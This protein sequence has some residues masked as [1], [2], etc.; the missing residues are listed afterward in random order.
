MLARAHGILQSRQS[1]RRN[2]A[3]KCRF[4]L[5][6]FKRASQKKKSASVLPLP[7][8]YARTQAECVHDRSYKTGGT[9]GQCAK[10]AAITIAVNISCVVL[11]SK[12]GGDALTLHPV[13]LVGNTLIR[14]YA[15]C[16]KGIFS[17]NLRG[18][19]PLHSPRLSH[20]SWAKLGVK[21]APMTDDRCS[22]EPI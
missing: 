10:V 3:E 7:L 16:H 22:I 21:W 15:F 4:C 18:R 5:L 20:F 9:R 1:L 14:V 6:G 2:A 12:R 8:F 13:R 11:T 17:R 19:S